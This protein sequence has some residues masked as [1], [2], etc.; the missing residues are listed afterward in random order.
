MKYLI[1]ERQLQ[2]IKEDDIHILGNENDIEGFK[3]FVGNRYF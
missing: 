3:N 2:L 1:T